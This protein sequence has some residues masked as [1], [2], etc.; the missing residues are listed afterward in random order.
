MI[1]FINSLLMIGGLA[2]AGAVGVMCAVCLVVWIAGGKIA[3]R[4]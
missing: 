4:K 1:N 3:T 2:A